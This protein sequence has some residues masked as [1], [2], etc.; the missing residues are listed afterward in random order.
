[1]FHLYLLFSF[2]CLVFLVGV[3]ENLHFFIKSNP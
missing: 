3:C 2:F 1:M